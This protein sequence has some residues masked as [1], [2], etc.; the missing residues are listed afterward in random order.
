MLQALLADRFRLQ[1]RKEIREVPSYVL[2]IAK[3]PKLGPHLRPSKYDCAA[4]KSTRKDNPNWAPPP[5]TD[6]EGKPLCT[7][8]SFSQPKSGVVTLRDA[9]PLESFIKQAQGHFDRKLVD[10]TGLS[11]NFE[12]SITFSINPSNPSDLDAIPILVAVQSELGLKVEVRPRPAEVYL[13]DSVTMP[14]P[15]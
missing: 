6:F 5:A 11:G 9:G 1:I 8:P 15:N 3:P 12:W 14:T 2:T 13:I 4:V 10:E 7:A